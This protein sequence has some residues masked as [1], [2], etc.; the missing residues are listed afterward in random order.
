MLSIGVM[1]S[2]QG[3]YYQQLA[4]EDYYLDGGEP[5][6]R[7]LGKGAEH[8]KLAGQAVEGKALELLLDGYSPGGKPL[9][10]NAGDKEHPE[11]RPGFDLTFS[12]PKTVSALWAIST[13]EV[14]GE[15]QTA[16]AAAVHAALDYLE[17]TAAFTRTGKRGVHL[18]Q[19]GITAALFEHGTSR[20]LDPQLHT[21]ALLMNV[22]VM[23]DGRTRALVHTE[24]FAHKMTAGAVYRVEL[25]AQLERRLGLTIEPDPTAYRKGGLGFKVAG[26][27]DDLCAMWSKRREGIEKELGA[28]G[29]ESASAAAAANKSTRRPKDIV[30]PRGELFDRWRQEAKSLGVEPPPRTPPRNR[31]PRG[32]A[33]A[34]D[35][36]LSKTLRELTATPESRLE[37]KTIGGR[38]VVR[39]VDVFRGKDGRAFG[40]SHFG[41]SLLLRRLAEN[42][43]GTGIDARTLIEKLS[44]AIERKAEG[45]VK[46][47]T[48]RTGEHLLTT[49]EVAAL[50]KRM[51]D[52]AKQL[53]K[54]QTHGLAESRVEAAIAQF[55]ADHPDKKLSPERQGVIKFL[56]ESGKGSLRCLEGKAG[57]AK[58]TALSVVRELYEGAG[59]R[60][61]GTAVPGKAVK[62]LREGGT[63]KGNPLS[64]DAMRHH[65]KQMWRA[66][67]NRPTERYRRG[68]FEN[69]YTL[70]M[71]EKLTDVRLHKELAH[72]AVQILRQAA[73]KPTFK[74]KPIVLDSKTVVICDEAS[75]V[76]TRQMAMLAQR[77]QRAG[78][79]LILAGD[80]GQIQAIGRGGSFAHL[81]DRFGKAELKQ[82]V[83]QRDPADRQA[84]KDA[85]AGRSSAVVES[86]ARRGLL[87]IEKDRDA[88]VDR[89]VTDW[90]R[91]ER[92]RKKHESLIFAG[93][94]EDARAINRRCQRARLDAGELMAFTRIGVN[95]QTMYKGDRVLFYKRSVALGVENGETG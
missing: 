94:N 85:S 86:F 15:I 93:T 50:E 74:Y 83:R 82:V 14:Q 76:D 38:T 60:V 24:F 67:R 57:T 52:A 26:V 16:Q 32:V 69:A 19:A 77:V 23:A 73:G 78:G 37:A 59:Y 72:H 41:E 87:A 79:I 63:E 13:P 7:W 75:M 28:W 29:L 22:G 8:F 33:K 58:T 31:E 30:P 10:Q 54:A 89:L 42:C 17:R 43:Q 55:N 21:H 84:V 3:R 53:G 92:G 64:P 65:A 61:I 49:R 45:I 91:L 48:S 44:A 36:A 12:A 90:S 6:G 47:A 5:V 71:F 20:A 56:A 11:R 18:H 62:S 39:I 51:L 2:G 81:A 88:T 95:G 66:A 46:L 9:V 70:A 80:R 40:L 1:A 25:A 35:A 4:R 27:S 68:L 34:F